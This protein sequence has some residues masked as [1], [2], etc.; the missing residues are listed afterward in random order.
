MPGGVASH[1]RALAHKWRPGLGQDPNFPTAGL[2]RSWLFQHR[3]FGSNRV[4]PGWTRAQ[5]YNRL[6][7]RVFVVMLAGLV[8]SLAPAGAQDC[9]GPVASVCP[10]LNTAKAIFVGTV[11]Q[12]EKDSPAISFHVTEAFKGIRGDVVDLDKGP[13]RFAF[14]LGKQYLVFAVP[15]GWRGAD[16]QCLTNSIC[17]G[18]RP[19]EDAAAVLEQLRAE[20]NGKQVAAVYGTLVRALG[21]E[22]GDWKDDYRRPLPNILVR[23]QSDKKSFES[24]TDQQGAYA[25]GRVP[26]G[27]YQVSA[28]L[29][30][31]LALG[32]LIGND[33][34]KPFDLPGG[35]CF[36]NDLYALPSGG[37]SGKVIGPDGTPLR[38]AVVYL[39]PASRYKEG[40]RGSYSLQGQGTPFSEWK[41]FEFHHL[42]GDDYVLVFNPKNEEQPD[43]P[44]PTTFYPDSASIEEAQIIHIADGQ[45]LSGADIHVSHPLP[46][47]QVAIRLLWGGRQPQDFYP[48]QVIVTA[49]RGTDPFPQETGQYAYTINVLLSARYT[50]HAEA[51]CRI[52]SKGQAESDD[53]TVDGSDPS[54]SEPTL[55]FV[56]GECARE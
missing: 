52:G 44:F 42:P 37:M 30:P 11:T 15:C 36:E 21:K 40:K 53:I 1:G 10:L 35:C 18:T 12:D 3:T 9:S 24:T 47:R 16:K 45:Q 20:K 13:D 38:L 23:L 33:P 27:K 7:R 17:S 4:R 50:I 22:R 48:P 5:A 39:Y 6:M 26:P 31:D 54:V 49:S 25:F 43:A 14:E 19:L 41:P 34:V 46:T 2:I 29:P 28:D 55:R 56:K 51:F 8:L 32:D